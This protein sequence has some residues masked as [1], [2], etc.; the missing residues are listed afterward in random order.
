MPDFEECW[1]SETFRYLMVGGLILL[2]IMVLTPNPIRD[3]FREKFAEIRSNRKE[4]RRV[5][6]SELLGSD[7]GGYRGYWGA[8][9]LYD[10][11]TGFK[12]ACHE[13]N[14][15]LREGRCWLQ[16]DRGGV[17]LEG[18]G[19]PLCNTAESFY[20]NH[21]RLPKKRDSRLGMLERSSK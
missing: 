13:K 11:M 3:A 19:L 7:R 14:K 16:Y 6:P 17:G 2:L 10:A 21:S 18:Q 5:A 9:D 12:C 1:N 15:I 8:P 20:N 4:H